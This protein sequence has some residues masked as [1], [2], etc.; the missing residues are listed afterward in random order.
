MGP[1][2]AG[3]PGATDERQILG[4]GGHEIDRANVGFLG[5]G[6]RDEL[7]ASRRV[8]G[9]PVVANRNPRQVARSVAR[10][11]GCP[12]R[13]RRCGGPGMVRLYLQIVRRG[14]V[15]AADIAGRI[16]QDRAQ[17]AFGIGLQRRNVAA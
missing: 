6:S 3:G 16:L 15:G 9:G 8:D 7:H 10:G 17:R 12:G 13:Y 5:G 4:G 14:D 1:C 11:I 2:R